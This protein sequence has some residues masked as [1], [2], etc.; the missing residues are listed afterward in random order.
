MG[1]YTLEGDAL[2]FSRMAGTMMACSE[3]METEK[4]YVEA[5]T[6]TRKWRIEGQQ[7]ELLDDAGNVLAV[8]RAR[9]AS[10]SAASADRSD[11]G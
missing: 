6:R 9:P 1:G 4:A 11:L 10:G 3:S 7:L 5:L 2:S 8:F